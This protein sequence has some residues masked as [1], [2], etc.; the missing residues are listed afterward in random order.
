M[1]PSPAATCICALA[2]GTAAQAQQSG[3]L[4]GRSAAWLLAQALLSLAVVVGV[5]YLMYFG[6]RRISDRQAGAAGE[7]PL[8]VV[9]AR[10]LGGDRWLY[11][12]RIG[13]R[14][15]VIGGATGQVTAIADLGET[16]AGD[17]AADESLG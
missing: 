3:D 8:R 13:R 1:R 12:I 17:D 5:I 7:G 14:L 11:L 4:T 6:L 16:A 2:A 9:Q 15:L 10:H